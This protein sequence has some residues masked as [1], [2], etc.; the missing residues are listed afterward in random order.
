MSDLVVTAAAECATDV[1]ESSVSQAT[2]KS[3]TDNVEAAPSTIANGSDDPACFWM[4]RGDRLIVTLFC[5][6]L[7]IL[8][9]VKWLQ[10]T[11]WGIAPVKLSS[12]KPDE[13]YYT[14]DINTASWV[15]WSQLDGIGEKLARRIV[16]DREE[17]GPFRNPAD[18][19]RVAGIR[20][21]V[22]EKMKPFLQGGTDKAESLSTP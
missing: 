1:V 20:P 22:L 9:G 10:L 11:R 12:S 14:L 8:L 21:A 6:I 19:G 13:Y 7:L 4:R 15:E 2:M 5:A 17:R 16:A 18:V 3:S